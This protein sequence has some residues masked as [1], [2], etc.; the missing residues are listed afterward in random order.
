MFKLIRR[1]NRNPVYQSYETGIRYELFRGGFS[2]PQNNLPSFVCVIGQQSEEGEL[3]VLIEYYDDDDLTELTK[4]Y[5]NLQDLYHFSGWIAQKEGDFK[6]YENLLDK[7]AKD[8]NLSIYLHQPSIVWD[9]D[10][11]VQIIKREMRQ[12]KLLFPKDGILQNQIEKIDKE[13]S[14]KEPEKIEKY[15]P[16]MVLASILNEFDSLPIRLEKSRPKDAWAAD[17]ED[18]EP[19]PYFSIW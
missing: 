1:H 2:W 17:F 18:D 8:N 3:R 12:N 13:A 9:L 15:A 4:R 10:L 14:L 7:D 6:S 11:A 19:R 16:T 5:G